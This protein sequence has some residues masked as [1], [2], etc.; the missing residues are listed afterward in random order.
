M[1]K[2][3][4]SN[5]IP[6]NSLAAGFF[7]HYDYCDSYKV[8]IDKDIS[9]DRA[10]TKIFGTRSWVDYLLEIRNKIVKVFGLRTDVTLNIADYYPVGSKA[11][12]FNVVARN[13]NEILMS[14]KD[15]H[16][17]FAVSVLL[18]KQAGGIFVNVTTIVKYNMM[19]GRIYFTF[20]KPFHRYIVKS[21]VK[22][23]TVL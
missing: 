21:S 6:E 8:K 16:L 20:V 13:E 2:I 17:D 7:N 1:S 4:S 22:N 15:K 5:K 18:E 9:V 3:I 23:I 11:V 14:E 10:A 12:M 19:L